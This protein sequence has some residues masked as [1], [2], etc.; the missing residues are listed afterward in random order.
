VV[1]ILRERLEIGDWL[2]AYLV[3]AVGVAIGI[4]IVLLT[5]SSTASSG[6][7]S[8]DA[9]IPPARA[10]RSSPQMLAAEA[11]GPPKASKREQPRHRLDERGIHL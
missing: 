11:T 9:A 4:C 10:G 8:E 6:S 3:V 7:R 5:D 2:W 1:K